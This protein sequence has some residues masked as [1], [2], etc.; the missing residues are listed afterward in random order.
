[1]K[2]L[3]FDMVRRDGT[4]MPV[5]LNATAV[6]DFSGKQVMSRSSLFDITNRKRAEIE[7][8][9]L[10]IAVEQSPAV[11]VIT[12]RQGCIE[13]VNPKFTRVTGYTLDE[14]RGKN[15][16]ILKAGRTPP[17]E[18]ERF[19]QTILSGREWRGE[20]YNRKK[21]GDYYWEQAVIA[22]MTNAD[23]VC[24]HFI[25][26]K[27]DIT[28]RKQMEDNLRKAKNAAEAAN[29]AKSEFLSNMSHEIRTPMTA[30]MGFTDLLMDHSLSAP[31]ARPT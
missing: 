30:I 5:L 29:R 2:G 7:L 27:E 20:F 3:E 6:T 23:G 21:D 9:K 28:E 10:T 18:Y 17:N 31:T 14:A 8:K 25:A 16:R 19:W 22:P 24:T 11:I 12:D 1:M 26:V 15:P 13:Y 4:I